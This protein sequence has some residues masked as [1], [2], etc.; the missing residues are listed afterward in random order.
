MPWTFKPR[1]CG[2]QSQY[3]S[4]VTIFTPNCY[5]SLATAIRHYRFNVTQSLLT[6]EEA[7]QNC[8][9]AG[10]DLASILSAQDQS[11]INNL[12]ESKPYY[13]IGLNDRAVEGTFVWSDGS[14]LG[15]TNWNFAQPDDGGGSEDCAHVNFPTHGEWNDLPCSLKIK[16]ICKIP[17]QSRE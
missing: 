10:G 17:G 8:L 2:R 3:K 7:R 16:S 1:I 9:A 12:T 5:F 11:K 4:I 13:W 6:W 14:A 15:F